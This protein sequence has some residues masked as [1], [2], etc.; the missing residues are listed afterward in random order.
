MEEPEGI[1]PHPLVIYLDTK[2]KIYL[3]S[4]KPVQAAEKRKIG[5][6]R[7]AKLITEKHG[8]SPP[9]LRDL[10]PQRNFSDVLLTSYRTNFKPSVLILGINEFK[11]LGYCMEATTVESIRQR[12]PGW[13]NDEALEAINRNDGQTTCL[14]VER[15]VVYFAVQVFKG[16]FEHL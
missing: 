9:K 5:N 7:A 12:F 4:S 10:R 2:T 3:T 6:N 13:V 15:E 1:S 14:K 8:E 11:A 16:H